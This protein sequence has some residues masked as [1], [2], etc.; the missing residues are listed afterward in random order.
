MHR[1]SIFIGYPDHRIAENHLP[2]CLLL[3]FHGYHLTVL[4]TEFRGIRR[5][6]VDMP[7]GYDHA[8]LKLDFTAGTYDPARGGTG[9]VT[10]L[11]D[12]CD[13][14]HGARVGE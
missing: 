13:D 10:A 12:R 1:E 6:H 5:S 4:H 3:D 11:A 2:S 8:F 14:S 7:A 9:D